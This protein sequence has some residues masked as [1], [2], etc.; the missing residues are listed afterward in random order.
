EEALDDSVA[1]DDPRVAQVAAERHAFECALQAV[2]EESGLGEDDDALFD[3]WDTL[4]P[5]A[6]DG[7]EDAAGLSSGS[8]EAG[9]M[10]AR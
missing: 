9:S 2:I 1:A 10:S 5:A 6:A 4:H 8:R 7:G 3:A